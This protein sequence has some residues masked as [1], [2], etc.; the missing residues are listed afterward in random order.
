MRK[1]WIVLVVGWIGCRSPASQESRIYPLLDRWQGRFD[2]VLTRAA[3]RQSTSAVLPE[4]AALSQMES[5]LLLGAREAQPPAY[6]FGRVVYAAFDPAGGLVVV[7]EENYALLFFDQTG[8]FRLRLGRQGEGPGEFL[9][10]PVY[11]AFDRQGRLYVVERSS[12]RVHRFLKRNDTFMWNR[13]Y[14]LRTALNGEVL[15]GCLM[16]DTLYVYANP[17]NWWEQPRLHVLT[18]DGEHVRAFGLLDFYPREGLPEGTP[19]IM[20]EARLFCDPDHAGLILAYR[21]LPVV[22]SYTTEGRRRWRLRLDDV[23]LL[24][25]RIQGAIIEPIL[26]P[27]G[28]RFR[29]VVVFP[30]G[31]IV[32][33]VVEQVMRRDQPTIIDQ[34]R[35]YIFWI[36]PDFQDWG[37]LETS[38]PFRQLYDRQGRLWL[39]TPMETT[40]PRV[41]LFQLPENVSLAVARRP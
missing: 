1:I 13:T 35:T 28:I 27:R 26:R 20:L 25:H 29:N 40:L 32:L 10:P 2:L 15:G 30:S 41:A 37:W 17:L 31:V 38:L 16:Q 5:L 36:R 11:A 33:H 34:E 8:Q 9:A 23:P 18:L 39:G 22:E 19:P 3:D 21:Y 12:G 24:A 14:E 6:F 4:V 7:D